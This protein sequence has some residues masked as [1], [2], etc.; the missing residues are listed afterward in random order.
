[1]D[2]ANSVPW[3]EVTHQ[4]PNQMVR[5]GNHVS[6]EVLTHNRRPKE[7]FDVCLEGL[8]DRYRWM[9]PLV[10]KYCDQGLVSIYYR[11]HLRFTQLSAFRA[12]YE[13]DPD[14]LKP[15]PEL[16]EDYRFGHMTIY[17]IDEDEMRETPE[18]KGD[19]S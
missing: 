5:C 2:H 18:A 6:H 10:E 19:Y 1:M 15:T 3:W 17:M 7:H 13:N 14:A 8:Q 16:P 11:K 12:A 9:I 4:D